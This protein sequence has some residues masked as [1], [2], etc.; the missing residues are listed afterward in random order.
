MTILIDKAYKHVALLIPN[1]DVTLEQ[2]LQTLLGDDYIIHTH[3]MWLNDVTED[4]EKEMVRVELPL[5][6]KYLKNVTK[7]DCAIFGCTSASVAYGSQSMY[8]IQDYISKEL[9]CPAITAF[10]AVL[11][12]MENLKV[13]ECSLLTPYHKDVTGF[14]M[15]SLKKHNIDVNYFNGL[16]LISDLE[17]SEVL[18]SRIIDF[19]KSCY[20]DMPKTSM[21]CFLSCTNFRVAEIIEQLESVLKVKVISSNFCI[22][23]FI[24]SI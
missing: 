10:G 8:M 13:N 5:A 12:V 18:P 17:I 7:F 20:L 24:V 16:G 23:D 14:M 6:V 21:L 2:N 11:R 4:S 1:T 3:R 15:K 22:I 19:A 9:D